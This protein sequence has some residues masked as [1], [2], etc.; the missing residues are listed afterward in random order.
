MA[1]L[2]K[3]RVVQWSM[4]CKILQDKMQ[5]LTKLMSERPQWVSFVL[6]G[7][8]PTI[9]RGR[10]RTCRPRKIPLSNICL[11]KLLS[12]LGSLLVAKGLCRPTKKGTRTLTHSP[13]KNHTSSFELS[14]TITDHMGQLTVILEYIHVFFAKTCLENLPWHIGTAW[15]ATMAHPK[16]WLG[17]SQ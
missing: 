10:C 9:F 7:C 12:G 6:T 15:W 14:M 8:E 2:I 17:G 13:V 16:F 4:M 5:Q 1:S 11:F 3:M